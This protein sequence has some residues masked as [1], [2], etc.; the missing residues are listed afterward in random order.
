SMIAEGRSVLRSASYL[1]VIPGAALAVTVLG[2][3][4][5]SEG[6]VKALGDNGARTA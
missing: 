1:S 5:F 6:L 3:H 2:V 4:L